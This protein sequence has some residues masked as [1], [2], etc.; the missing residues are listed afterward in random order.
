MSGEKNGADIIAVARTRVGQ[1]YVLGAKVPK[2][3]PNWS[4]PWDCAEFASWCAYQ[5][6]QIVF[7]MRPA[8]AESGDA[9]SGFWFDD[10]KEP[11][12]AIRWQDALDVPGALLV[13][14]PRPKLIGHVSISLG[15]GQHTIEAR[16]AALGVN[17]FDGVASRPW[18]I[19]VLLPGV[20]YN[21]AGA[22]V[23][24]IDPDFVPPPL[25]VPPG[26]Y[27]LASPHMTGPVVL[28]IQDALAHIGFDPGP[29]DGDFGSMT[30]SAVASLQAEKHLELDGLVGKNTAGA[31]GLGWPIVP[32]AAVVAQWNALRQDAAQPLPAPTPPVV[33]GSRSIQRFIKDGA[34]HS[35]EFAD[36]SIRFVGAEVPYS[37][38]M[39]RRGLWQDRNLAQIKDVGVYAPAD[40]VGTHGKWAY[41]IRPTIKGESAGYFGRL[42]SYDRAAFTFG[43]PQLAAHT[44]D[45][46]LILL[47]RA[48]LALPTA[49]HY[50]PE[51][52][53]ASGQVT[54][55]KADGSRQNLEAAANVTRPNGRVE[56]QLSNFMAYLNPDPAK[57]GAEEVSA[58]AR[59]M[60][61]AK[62]DAQARDAQIDV[63]V[64]RMK[65]LVADAKGKLS[66]FD[67]TDW[68]IAIWV[69]DIRYQGRGNYAAI[70]VALA[71]P[72]PLGALSLIG[73]SYAE[74]RKTIKEDIALLEADGL[75]NGF[76]V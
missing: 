1:R 57:V 40:Y 71:Q 21:G 12:V 9:F 22:A 28:A 76:T 59:L 24:A 20:D 66:A 16:S 32:S 53:L 27:G 34:K 13:R 74:R 68:R 7:G 14:R 37:D 35:V 67:G 61:W 43:A 55:T 33:G 41:F 69:A 48:L 2:N 11:G 62:E 31:L 75:L 4:G 52:S 26:L 39:V 36:G 51:L 58:G 45:E 18:D 6:Y 56:S 47:F 44:P 73:G 42:N 38:D 70:K 60:A 50:F 63:L 15:D 10:A 72:D 30:H 54:W 64:R 29:L 25:R 46:N 65:K 23:T 8:N 19:G 3:N 5:T 49:Q 17:V